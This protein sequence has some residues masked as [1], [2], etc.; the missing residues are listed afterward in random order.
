MSLVSKR[1]R[2]ITRRYGKTLQGAIALLAIS[3]ASGNMGTT[4][5]SAEEAADP[6]IFCVLVPHFKDEYWLSVGY[7][8]E[9]EA[10]KRGVDLRFFEAGG[11]RSLER[12][13]Q[14][15][16]EC[17]DQQVD[18]IILAPVTS[19]HPDLLSTVSEVS[20]DLA[21]FSLVNELHAP[22]VAASVGVDW[23]D[24]GFGLG[25]YLAARNPKGSPQQSV[26]LVSGP[27]EAGWIKPLEQGLR[28]GLEESSLHLVAVLRADTG[29]RQQLAS[30]EEAFERFPDMDYLIGSAPAIEAAIGILGRHKN[31]NRPVLVSTYISHTIRRGLMN[32]R[33]L[34]APFDDPIAQGEMA[35]RVAVG[36]LPIADD[37]RSVGPD[38]VVLIREDG[39]F[40]HIE[41]SP[42]D[43]F[44]TID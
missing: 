35:I 9:Q 26:V 38:V 15:I 27:Q 5:V 6:R 23:Q 19:D 31:L 4:L 10:A 43:F 14:Q 42:S 24:M 2:R 13:I 41:L 7:G 12:Q 29:L 16:L 20:Q 33:V 32:G 39:R 37:S 18:A 25:Q 3:L 17:R 36:D 1:V 22:E 40:G 8:L 28:S 34:A 11:Y 30:V 21:V 44:P